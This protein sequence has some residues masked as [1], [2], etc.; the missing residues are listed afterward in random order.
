MDLDPDPD[1]DL[2]LDLDLCQGG[3]LPDGRVTDGGLLLSSCHMSGGLVAAFSEI[4]RTGGSPRPSLVA[5]Y[6]LGSRC[7]HGMAGALGALGQLQLWGGPG[8]AAVVGG[9][10]GQRHGCG[11]R[12]L[13]EAVVGGP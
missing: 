3:Y 11:A 8:A 2:D 7:G 1:L 5:H 9:A 6:G 12:A 4:K 13:G 10:L